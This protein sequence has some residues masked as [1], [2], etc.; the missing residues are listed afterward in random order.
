[1]LSAG[2]LRR[3]PAMSAAAEARR[4]RA[5]NTGATAFIRIAN[6]AKGLAGCLDTPR[7]IS[8]RAIG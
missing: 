5:R 6:A 7:W 3:M 1:M 4:F 2:I 8:S